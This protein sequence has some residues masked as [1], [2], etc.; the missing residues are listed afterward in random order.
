MPQG[1]VVLLY[2]LYSAS[3]LASKEIWVRYLRRPKTDQR[4]TECKGSSTKLA[5]MT[6]HSPTSGKRKHAWK[7]RGTERNP[8]RSSNSKSTIKQHAE[9]TDHNMTPRDAQI[10]ERSATNYHSS[11]TQGSPWSLGNSIVDSSNVNKRKP[12][13]ALTHR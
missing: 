11:T 10:L 2:V 12:F 5:A 4:L 3:L 9:T 13:L 1:F 8:G 7:S 6:E